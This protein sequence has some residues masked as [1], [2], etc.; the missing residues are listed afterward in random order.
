MQVR[1]LQFQTLILNILSVFIVS[2]LNFQG[3][4]E[5]VL[6]L[7]SFGYLNS[8]TSFLSSV[9]FIPLLLVDFNRIYFR[10]CF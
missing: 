6:D 2:D 3:I 7:L 5:S 8:D 10:I 9:L 4:F 1:D